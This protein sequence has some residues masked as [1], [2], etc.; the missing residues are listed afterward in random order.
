[1]EDA[2]L[3]AR[4]LAASGAHREERNRAD[5]FFSH[6]IRLIPIYSRT[7]TGHIL[8]LYLGTFAACSHVCRVEEKKAFNA[9][10]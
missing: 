2:A 1:M 9:S 6:S 4:P 3:V 7:D 5:F 10:R 8:L